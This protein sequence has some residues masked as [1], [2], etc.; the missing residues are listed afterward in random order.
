M[1]EAVP[2]E[3]VVVGVEVW[4]SP[5]RSSFKPLHPFSARIMMGDAR[6]KYVLGLGGLGGSAQGHQGSQH[7]QQNKTIRSHDS[8]QS[9]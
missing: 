2:D 5:L 3:G 1:K 8:S 7:R 4:F 9:I 6:G